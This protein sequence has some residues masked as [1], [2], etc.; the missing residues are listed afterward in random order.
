MHLPRWSHRVIAV[1]F[2][3]AAGLSPMAFGATAMA[4]A[5]TASTTPRTWY[6]QVGAQNPTTS[7]M[8]MVFL[9]GDLTVNQGDTIVWKAGSA[10]PHTVTFVPPG[11]PVPQF[12]PQVFFPAGGSSYDGQGFFNSGVMATVSANVIGLPFTTQTYRLTINAPVGD[13]IYYCAVHPG[14]Q[15]TIHVHAPGTPY[16]HT[17]QYYNAAAHQ[18]IASIIHHGHELM[19]QAR[20]VS[21][22][23]HIAV[24]FTQGVVDVMRFTPST[25]YIRVGQSVTF[26]SY[27][28]GPHTVTFGVEQADITVPYGDPTHYD[29]TYPLN[30]GFIFMPQTFTVTFTKAGT[31]HYYCGLHDYMG[32]M[33]TIIVK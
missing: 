11:Q 2:A 18:R 17:Q 9:P 19:E 14:M 8:G 30:S 21:D 26:T 29:G 22:N 6:V 28:M 23:H 15:A 4:H 16:P 3:F 20:D 1:I 7:I 27:A 31:Y 10:E 33:G 13:Y 32:M 25:A 24:G 5:S 12:G